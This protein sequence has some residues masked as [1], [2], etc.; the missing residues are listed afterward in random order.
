[1]IGSG[2]WPGYWKEVSVRIPIVMP[3]QLVD[4]ASDGMGALQRLAEVAPR[5]S[6]ILDAAERLLDQLSALLSRIDADETHARAVNTRADAATCATAEVIEHAT[7]ISTQLTPLMD[8]LGA[9]EVE[10]ILDLVIAAPQMTTAVQT[11]VL[12][13][14]NTLKTVA[15]DLAEL[16]VVSRTLNE[17]LGSLPGLGRVKKRVDEQM[18]DT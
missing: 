6:A 7:S 11:D 17:I 10:A 12:P 9:H 2:G 13:M 8:R 4:R 1:M 3:A 15:P 18:E 16:L 14:V 5:A